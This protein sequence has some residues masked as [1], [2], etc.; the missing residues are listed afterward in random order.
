MD[1]VHQYDNPHQKD[2]SRSRARLRC[3][4]LFL[5]CWVGRWVSR[6]FLLRRAGIHLSVNIY[7]SYCV[8]WYTY[9]RRICPVTLVTD[10]S[11][12]DDFAVYVSGIDRQNSNSLLVFLFYSSSSCCFCHPSPLDRRCCM[13]IHTWLDQRQCS[14][15]LHRKRTVSMNMSLNGKGMT[16]LPVHERQSAH[17]VDSSRTQYGRKFSSVCFALACARS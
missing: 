7:H 9:P 16:H 5:V 8:G 13:C 10:W 17:F 15:V 2:G 14:L 1:N 11:L 6:C 3:R 4:A 12:A